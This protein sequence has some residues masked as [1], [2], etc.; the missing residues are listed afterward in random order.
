VIRPLILQI[1]WEE[2]ISWI[3]ELFLENAHA[4]DSEV[5]ASVLGFGDQKFRTFS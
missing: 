3:P 1:N 4:C 2:Q 5:W